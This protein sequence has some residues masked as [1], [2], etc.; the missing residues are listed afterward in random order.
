MI[1]DDNGDTIFVDECQRFRSEQSTG[2]STSVVYLFGGGDLEL[3]T[4][5]LCNGTQNERDATSLYWFGPPDSK[6]LRLVLDMY[7]FDCGRL[8]PGGLPLPTLYWVTDKVGEP[9]V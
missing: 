1:T 2:G 8:V 4:R 3:R 9:R 5:W 6:T 7:F